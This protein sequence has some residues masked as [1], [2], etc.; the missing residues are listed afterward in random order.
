MR[1]RSNIRTGAQIRAAR[2][3]VGLSQFTLAEE[4]GTTARTIR[5]WERRERPP[6]DAPIFKGKVEEAFRR[7][8][9]IFVTDPGIGVQ[10]SE[11]GSFQAP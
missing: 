6:S 11:A 1:N 4:V 9:V 7:R 3:L 8:G 2:A 10:L 5:A